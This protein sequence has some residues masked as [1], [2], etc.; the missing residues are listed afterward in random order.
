M[1]LNVIQKGGLMYIYTDKGMKTR[2]GYLVSFTGS[3]LSFVTSPGSQ[4][5]IVLDDK[6]YRIKSFN[7]PKKITSGPGWSK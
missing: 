6:L 7:A 1:I 4:L 3:S 5:I 2:N